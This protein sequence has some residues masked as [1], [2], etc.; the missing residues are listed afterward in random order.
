[1][2]SKNLFKNSK[3]KLLL[4][5]LMIGVLCMSLFVV[6]CNKKE[7]ETKIPDYSYTQTDDEFISNASFAYGVLDTELTK[8]PKTSPTGWSKSKDSNSDIGSSTAKS[9]AVNVTTDGWKELMNALYKDSNIIDYIEFQN[10]AGLK[11]DDTEY[12]DIKNYVKALLKAQNNT[13]PSSSEIQ[14]YI[15]ENYF[16]IFANPSLH[17]GAKDDFVYMLNNYRTTAYQQVGTSQKITSS[18]EITLNKGE[19][20]KVSVWI[21]TQNITEKANGEYGANIRLINKFNGTA[22]SDFAINN[23]IANE[24]T[25]YTIYVKADE[26]FSTSIKVALGLGYGLVGITEGTAYFDD[27]VFTHLTKEE[28]N[29]ETANLSKNITTFEYKNDKANLINSTSINNDAIVYDLS[30][31]K[32][33]L[34]SVSFDVNADYTKSPVD[35]YVG[36]F[37]GG[38][39]SNDEVDN[40]DGYDNVLKLTLKDASYTLKL[41]SDDFKVDSEKSVYVEFYIK[42]QLSSWGSTDITVNLYDILGATSKLREAITTVSTVNEEWQKVGLVIKNNFADE[43]TREFAIEIVVGPTDIVSAKYHYQFASGEVYI[44]P[45]MIYNNDNSLDETEN[46]NYYGLYSASASATTAL[47]AGYTSDYTDSSDSNAYNFTT[48]PSDIGVISHSPANINGYQGV[49]ADHYYIKEDSTNFEVNTKATAGLINTKYLSNYGINNLETALEFSSE[50]KDYQPIM[51]YNETEDNYGFIGSAKTISTSS[52]AKI[53]VTLRVV[54][55]AKAFIYLVNVSGQQKNVLT[56]EDFTS[57]EKDKSLQIDHTGSNYRFE[58]D[59]T[60]DMMINGW[61]TVDFYIATGASEKDFRVEVWNG[62]RN[63]AVKSQGFVFVKDITVTTSGAFTEPTSVNDAFTTSGNP[64][65][66]ESSETFTNLIKHKRAWTSLEEE[67]NEKHPNEALEDMKNNYAPKYVWATN[68]T[69]VYAI[70]NTIDPVLVDPDSHTHDEEDATSG[71]TAET[72]PSTFWLSFSSIILAVVLL[73]A[74]I[75]LFVKNIRRRHKANKSDAKSHYTITSRVKAK[76]KAEKKARK[77]NDEDVDEIEEV[78]EETPETELEQ[79]QINEEVEESIETEQV[80]ETANDYVYGDVEV[81]G[82]EE[83]KKDE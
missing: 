54:D 27:V 66:D 37:E 83:E 71:C 6:A 3:T 18:S 78:I 28:F 75:A 69:F 62:D 57:Y 31:E 73:A 47:Y 61:L 74:I 10:K 41:T 32:G 51:I 9:G 70:F 5:F 8:F 26:N 7:D 52:Y 38:S 67:F 23:I 59:V 43:P 39:A 68:E 14:E 15:I 22:Q 20:G 30:L 1:M 29:I 11:I 13:T 21:K 46:E 19:Y 58:L 45:V 33:L 55:D 4:I 60:S 17:E 63:G 81:F 2:T 56:F 40:I 36:K 76:K 44:T 72:D 25:Q 50:D 82:N 35:G 24:W 80:E 65:F 12:T 79:E 34:S 77:V 53:S 49:V 48:A 64:L 16:D 42:N